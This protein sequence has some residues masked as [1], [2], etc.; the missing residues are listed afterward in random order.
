MKLTVLLLYLAAGQAWPEFRGANGS[1]VSATTGLPTTFDGR[2]NVAWSVAVPPGRSSP[3]V[4]GRRLFLTAAEGPKLLVLALDVRTGKEE[5][6]YS[7]DRSRKGEVD[8]RYNDPASP[9]PAVDGEGVYA[10]FPDFGLVGVSLS[11]RERWRLSLGPFLNNYGMASSPI[12]RSESVLLQCDQ[13]RDSF[14]LAVDRRTGSVRW[15]RARPSTIE[16]WSTPIVAMKA[17]ANWEVLATN[18][19]AEPISASP[20][21]ADGALFVRTQSRLYCFRRR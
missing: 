1:G 18:D 17:S 16:G 15:R 11:G 20:A 7:L 13:A 9:T 5:W 8:D 4:S 2:T 19:L 10:F 3:I 6:R 21:I 12:V 14:L